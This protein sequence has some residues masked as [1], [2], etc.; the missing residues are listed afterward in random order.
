MN[1]RWISIA[2]CAGVAAL[3]PA[4][5]LADANKP[6]SA[7]SDM[8]VSR[9]KETGQ[10]R[11]PSADEEAALASKSRMLAPNV[12]VL[13]RPVTTMEFRSDGSAVMKRTLDDMDNLVLTRQADGRSVIRHGGPTPNS[14]AAAASNK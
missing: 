4:L 5:S 2:V 9:D 8:K 13:R 11:A 10:L 1:S 14:T 7:L 6:A 3:A 12:V